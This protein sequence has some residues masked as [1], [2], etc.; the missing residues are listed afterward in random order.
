VPDY[1]KDKVY[2]SDMK[3]LVIWYGILRKNAPEVLEEEADK[4]EEEVEKK[5]RPAPKAKKASAKPSN[6]TKPE[7]ADQKST[8]KE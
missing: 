5:E 3:K 7:E 2:V 8:D 4:L 1:D 6:D